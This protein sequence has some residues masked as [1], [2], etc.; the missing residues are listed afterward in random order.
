MVNTMGLINNHTKVA[1]L[2][3]ER[4]ESSFPRR[5]ESK[6]FLLKK[7]NGFPITTSGMTPS[8][9]SPSWDKRGE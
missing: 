6:L 4:S 5:R 9:G 2:C 7:T 1:D 3:C 8:A